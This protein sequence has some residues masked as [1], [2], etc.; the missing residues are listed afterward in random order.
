MVSTKKV[1]KPAPRV[2][3]SASRS[4]AVRH[5]SHTLAPEHLG[6]AASIATL[7][8][9]VG[10][11]ALIITAVSIVVG[12]LTIG[13]R[14]ADSTPPNIAQL[15]TTQ[16]VGGIVL[17]LLS[18]GV[19]AAA[20]AVLLDVRG[21]RGVAIG[22]GALTAA[23]CVAGVLLVMTV[24]GGDRLVALALLI[25]AVLFG[26]SSIILLRTRRPSTTD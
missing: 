9:G 11:V 14:Y 18:M 13:S 1:T 2:I 3:R 8:L 25:G 10:G 26:A 19:V 5:R 7:V 16:V 24:G 15:G 6:E 12:G 21:G 4:V 20:A 22:L 17:L 23:L